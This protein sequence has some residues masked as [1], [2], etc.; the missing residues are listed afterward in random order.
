MLLL[1]LIITS[2]CCIA[3][4]YLIYQHI[5]IVKSIE[6][7]KRW[8]LLRNEK[9]R[10]KYHIEYMVYPKKHNWYGLRWPREKDYK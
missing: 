7:R 4:F 9:K 5:R 1:I 6:I 3:I 8:A 2:I 10:D